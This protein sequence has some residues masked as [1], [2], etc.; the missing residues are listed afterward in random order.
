MTRGRQASSSTS[1]QHLSRM[2]W[3]DWFLM[4]IEK[5]SPDNYTINFGVPGWKAHLQRVDGF[6]CEAKITSLS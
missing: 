5:L 3:L 4:A 6:I 2:F 1:P